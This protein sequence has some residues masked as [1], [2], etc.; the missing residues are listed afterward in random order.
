MSGFKKQLKRPSKFYI[1]SNLIKSLRF[2]DSLNNWFAA[3]TMKEMG[4]C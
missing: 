4:Y 2:A 1:R 3:F